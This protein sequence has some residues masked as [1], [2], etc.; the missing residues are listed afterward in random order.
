LRS[1][2]KR[3]INAEIF[4]DSI[5]TVF[6]PN[7]AEVRTLDEFAEEIGV[8]LMDDCPSHVTHDIAGLPTEA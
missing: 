5:R 8:L 2:P 6:L 4:L 1:N 3:Y 7:L